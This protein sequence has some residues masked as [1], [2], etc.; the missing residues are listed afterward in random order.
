MGLH[1][2]YMQSTLL[3]SN[4]HYKLNFHPSQRC[5]ICPFSLFYIVLTLHK[6]YIQV[7]IISLVMTDSTLAELTVKQYITEKKQMCNL[8]QILASFS[9]CWGGLSWGLNSMPGASL[10]PSVVYFW[11]RKIIRR[12]ST[13]MKNALPRNTCIIN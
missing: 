4:L 7:K 2:L 8:R 10:C 12:K 11:K 5:Y 3:K 6:T 1:F 13:K 9:N